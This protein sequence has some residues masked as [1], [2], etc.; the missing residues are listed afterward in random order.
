VLFDPLATQI[1]W[2]SAAT[3]DE[4]PTTV[5][6]PSGLFTFQ[7]GN[8]KMHLGAKIH[9]GG[10]LCP[11]I[12]PAL[13]TIEDDY[14]L[15]RI[16][17]DER[18]ELI[19]ERERY[20]MWRKDV[21]P[22]G[23]ERWV[24]PAL[25]ANERDPRLACSR[26]PDSLK[27]EGLQIV[28]KPPKANPDPEVEQFN[29]CTAKSV[30]IDPGDYLLEWQAYAH[31]GPEW[32]MYFAALRNGVERDN[33]QVKSGAGQALA[34]AD[35]RYLRGR[36]NNG[37]MAAWML[38]GHNV[39][40]LRSWLRKAMQDKDGVLVEAPLKNRRGD[41]R[42]EHARAAWA[43]AKGARGSVKGA[44]GSVKGSAQPAVADAAAVDAG[45]DPPDTS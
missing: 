8:V 7:A 31:H 17:A 11:G 38:M 25:A 29:V 1:P 42:P 21:L 37:L 45:P 23:K 6:R 9:A 3:N 12:E 16:D 33:S 40:L 5:G 30:T 27:V 2:P 44:R 39:D 24:C 14:N 41:R 22:N 43:A 35:R 20:R 18:D 36:A 19:A 13:L 15:H 4:N 28:P 32:R 10:P 26:R 34:V